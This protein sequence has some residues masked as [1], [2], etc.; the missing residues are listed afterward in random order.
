VFLLYEATDGCSVDE[1]SGRLLDQA[2][3]CGLPRPVTRKTIKAEDNVLKSFLEETRYVLVDHTLVNI[4]KTELRANALGHGAE[5]GTNHRLWTTCNKYP[6]PGSLNVGSLRQK[7]ENL[8]DTLGVFALIKRI[9][10]HDKR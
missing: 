1:Q 7:T 5:T 3:D 10:N 4:V 8:S 2:I 6:E 9:N